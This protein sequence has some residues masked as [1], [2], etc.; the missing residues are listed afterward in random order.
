MGSGRRR[1]SRGDATREIVIDWISC[2]CLSLVSPVFSIS[3][4]VCGSWS[5]RCPFASRIPW[6]DWPWMFDGLGYFKVFMQ[7]GDIKR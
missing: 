2:I 6:A 5:C 1:V 3:E 7:I 4:G